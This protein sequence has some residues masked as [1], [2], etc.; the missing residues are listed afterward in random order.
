MTISITTK[1]LILCALLNNAQLFEVTLLHPVTNFLFLSEK[2]GGDEQKKL[3]TQKVPLLLNYAQ[4][5]LLLGNFYPVIE[6][7]TEALKI[8]P[9]SLNWL[10]IC[11]V[12]CCII[13]SKDFK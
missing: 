10:K 6:H 11:F 3:D 2:P 1:L 8:A 7:T 9:G 4:C 5:Q 12:M 13:S